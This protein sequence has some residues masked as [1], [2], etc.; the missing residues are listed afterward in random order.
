[1]PRHV[2]FCFLTVVIVN[3]QT[4]ASTLDLL[5]HARSPYHRG[6]LQGATHRHTA[7]HPTCGDSVCLQLRV[8]GSGELDSLKTPSVKDEVAS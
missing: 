4:D 8:G 2:T 7:R 3:L 5:D 1:M 6:W